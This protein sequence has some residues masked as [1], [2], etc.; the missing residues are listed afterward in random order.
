MTKINW[1]LVWKTAITLI[2]AAIMDVIVV[3]VSKLDN[4]I[5]IIF[6]VALALLASL[7]IVQFAWTSIE[8]GLIRFWHRRKK[9][10]IRHWFRLPQ[11]NDLRLYIQ[12][13]RGAKPVRVECSYENYTDIRGR[14]YTDFD[15]K[16]LKLK[17][18]RNSRGHAPIFSD[19]LVSNDT[20]EIK[21]GEA[22]NGKIALYLGDDVPIF[23]FEDGRYEYML[24]FMLDRKI[25]Q[26]FS[27]LLVIKNGALI[28]IKDKL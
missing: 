4:P 2:L 11:E 21:V 19:T 26:T 27:V 18:V 5:S 13:P 25:R 22:Y 1:M 15:D 16:R 23:G 24:R 10:R 14:R 6:A 28:E 20:R 12:N 3:I 17:I 8:Q 7:A 9:S